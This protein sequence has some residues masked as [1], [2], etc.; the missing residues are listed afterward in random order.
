[1]NTSDELQH[2][3]LNG[4]ADYVA[5][6]DELCGLAQHSLYIFE[7]DF[8][9]L[10]FNNEARYTKMRNFLLSSPNVRLHLLAHD[11]Q[12]LVRFCPRIMM[13]MR[14][15]S[16][17]MHIYQTPPHLRNVSEPFAVADEKHFVRRFHFDDARGIFAQN[18]HEG[19][20]LLKSRFEEMWASS[21][22]SATATTLGL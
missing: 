7:N 11:S 22:P 13:L 19:A 14:Q 21:H 15:F 5:A 12:P 16:H 3:P 18:D 17:S 9:N 2:T 6:L 10:G 4:A 20:R 1:M 8:D